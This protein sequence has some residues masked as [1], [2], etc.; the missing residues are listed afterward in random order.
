MTWTPETH[1]DYDR[2]KGYDVYTADNARLG[3]V[4]HVFHPLQETADARGGHYFLVEPDMEN[5]PLG[6][7]EVFVPERAVR[8]VDPSEDMII[9]AIPTR[10]LADQEWNRPSDFD[11]YRRT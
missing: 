9:L 5:P 7:S 3:K 8:E 6:S 4:M 2:V 10:E 1:E 11:R